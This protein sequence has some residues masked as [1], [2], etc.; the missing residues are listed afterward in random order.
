MSF[1]HKLHGNFCYLYYQQL[2]NIKN[3]PIMDGK[4]RAWDTI[5]KQFFKPV[6]K[7]ATANNASVYISEI[8]LT[9]AGEVMHRLTQ[10]GNTTI[11]HEMAMEFRNRYKI[12]LRA[13]IKDKDNK[14][15]YIN[16]IVSPKFKHHITGAIES[17][18]TNGVLLWDGDKFGIGFGP[19]NDYTSI[20]PISKEELQA[21]EIIGN[22]YMD[23]HLIMGIEPTE[24]SDEDKLLNQLKTKGN[25][26]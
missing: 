26:D 6:Y 21:S 7:R 13:G 8:L 5:E 11:I 9:Q 2:K 4:F 19:I 12:N 10:D 25:T 3:K 22:I 17:W 14:K 18:G 23:R 24:E 15:Y 20:N 1:D 16:D